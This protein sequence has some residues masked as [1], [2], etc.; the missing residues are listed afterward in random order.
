MDEID[1]TLMELATGSGIDLI[2]TGALPDGSIDGTLLIDMLPYL[3]KESE[4]SREDF[5]PTLFDAMLINGGLYEYTEKFS[6]LTMSAPADIFPDKDSFTVQNILAQAQAN[7]D[8]LLPEDWNYLVDFFAWAASAEFCDWKNGSCNFNDPVF[9]AWLD[10]LK[11]LPSELV[12]ITRDKP[13]LF[14]INYEFQVSAGYF[15]RQRSGGEYIVPGFPE[16]KGTG[17]YFMKLGSGAGYVGSIDSSKNIA[18][19]GQCTR[20]GIMASGDNHDGAWRFVKTLMLGE[21]APEL[22]EGIPVMKAS[23]ERALDSRLSKAKSGGN[24]YDTFNQYDADCMRNLVYNSTGIVHK[25]DALMDI[26]R[27][28]INAFLGGKGTTEECAERIQSRVSIYMAE[29]A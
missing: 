24:D 29:Q 8:L 3:D 1:K 10:L 2:D 18:T 21:T 25:D 4:I 28:E 16:T 26:F 6:M 7:P 17:T 11:E 19:L 13:N 27:T 20:I 5:I 12:N 23:F 22:M 9:T 14:D 15:A